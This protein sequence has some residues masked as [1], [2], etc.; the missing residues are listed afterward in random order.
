MGLL[1]AAN[2]RVREIRCHK[3]GSE[4]FKSGYQYCCARDESQSAAN[5]LA[6]PLNLDTSAPAR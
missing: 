5:Y 6:F 3:A 4:K 1:I 2:R